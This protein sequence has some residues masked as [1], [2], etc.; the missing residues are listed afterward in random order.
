MR[1]QHIKVT[2]KIIFI[3]LDKNLDMIASII[4]RGRDHGLPTY[5][6]GPII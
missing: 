3:F 4:H 6:Q 5:K 2:N 1:H